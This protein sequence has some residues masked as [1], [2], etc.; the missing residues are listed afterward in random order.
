M[1]I[2]VVIPA[3]NENDEIEQTCSSFLKENI[4]EIFI[5]DDGSDVPLPVF[6]SATNIRHNSPAG[7]SVCRNLGGKQAT[8][9]VIVFSD[10][11]VR[12][13]NL[14][15]ICEFAVKNNAVA[16]PSMQSLNG[17]GKVTGYCRDFIL[18][19][20]GNELI[21]FN[22]NNTR[23]KA[24][25]CYCY[26]NWGGFFVVPKAVFSAIDGWV[27]HQHWGY[28]DPSLILKCFFCNIDTVLDQ[29][30]MYKHKGKVKTGFG[31]PV[32]AIEPL[33]N[34]FHSYFVI[35]DADTFQDYWLPL[36]KK[37]HA[38]MYEKGMQFI[39]AP[40]I[41]EEE[42]RFKLLKQRKD[43]DFFDDFIKQTKNRTEYIHA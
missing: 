28:N 27:N 21:G 18:K 26:G 10:A 33:L 42:K 15:K 19:G 39:S 29:N 7:P 34:I 5:Y 22:M 43:S 30:A 37:E 4:H 1:K 20:K 6:D 3:R 8:G 40:E 32:R 14:H 17:S 31:Y 16:I 25:Q 9:D 12:V 35:F 2:S 23:P 13:E 38:W 41:I 11:H 24:Q 36:L